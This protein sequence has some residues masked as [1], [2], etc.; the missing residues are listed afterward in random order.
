MKL[1]LMAVV[2]VVVIA[3]TPSLQ[4]TPTRGQAELIDPYFLA[5]AAGILLTIAGIVLINIKVNKWN[6]QADVAEGLS[7]PGES[8]FPRSWKHVSRGAQ[9]EIFGYKAL[10]MRDGRYHSII[11][12]DEWQGGQL[13]ADAQPFAGSGHGIYVAKSTNNPEIKHYAKLPGVAVF[14]VRLSGKL[15]ETEIFFRAERARIIGKEM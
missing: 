5:G 3:L 2:L 4:T 9:G 8:V 14:K 7:E 13:Q 15:I 10:V 6:H 12:G 1:L 11:H